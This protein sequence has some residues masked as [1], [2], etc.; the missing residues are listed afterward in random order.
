VSQVEKRV[1]GKEK[2][3]A[4]K[5]IVVLTILASFLL[6]ATA[7]AAPTV[8]YYHSDALGS[9][10]AAS[11]ESGSLLWRKSYE[12]YGDKITDGENDPN[13]IAYTGRKHDD[14]TGLTYMGARYY[15]PEVGRFSGID[16]VGISLDNPM[17]FNRY[18]SFNNNPYKYVDPDGKA[19]QALEVVVLGAGAFLV[20]SAFPGHQ[21]R[22]DSLQRL[23]SS[24]SNVFSESSDGVD[25]TDAEVDGVVS[26]LDP[27]KDTRGRNRK[28]QF[29]DDSGKSAEEIVDSLTG[30]VVNDRGDKILPDGSRVGIHVSSGTSG[31]ETGEFSGSDTVS[32]T[33]P[34]GKQ[35]IKIRVPKK[36]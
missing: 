13:A 6:G 4:S 3:S 23:V 5:L 9:A 8:T 15:D 30:E 12:P 10:V 26:G 7:Q 20:S 35:S 14:V 19:A 1:M 24:A 34:K 17:S 2:R 27:V 16:P 29:V 28:G 25:P 18:A 22:V 33:R 31:G 21:E 11:D 32:I 36:D